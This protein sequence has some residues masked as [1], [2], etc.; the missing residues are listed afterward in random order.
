MYRRT[1]LAAGAAIIAPMT[2][3]SVTARDENGGENDLP[4][5]VESSVFSGEGTE[6]VTDLEIEDGLTIIQGSHEGEAGIVIEVIPSENDHEFT[7]MSETAAFIDGDLLTGGEYNLYVDGEDEWEVT[8]VQPRP[9]DEEPEEL[10]L[11]LAGDGPDWTGPI[12]FEAETT[13]AGTHTG[14]SDFFVNTFLDDDVSELVFHALGEF[15]GATTIR[16]DS[17]GYLIIDADDDWALELE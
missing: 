10:P 3:L 6:I 17:A 1:T 16:G 4:N 8:V 2:G 13:V 5:E 12:E 7:V 11:S 9:A 14:E 15:S